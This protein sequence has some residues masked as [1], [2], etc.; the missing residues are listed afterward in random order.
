M[1]KSQ[2]FVAKSDKLSNPWYNNIWKEKI[3]SL[4]QINL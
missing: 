3:K 4:K 2:V 1:S